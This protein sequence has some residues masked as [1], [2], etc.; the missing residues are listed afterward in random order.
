[1][2]GLLQLNNLSTFE[3]IEKPLAGKKFAGPQQTAAHPTIRFTQ[4]GV[5]S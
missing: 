3:S 1:M 4:C 2:K 5:D